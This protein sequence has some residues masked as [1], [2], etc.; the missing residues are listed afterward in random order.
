MKTLKK[1]NRFLNEQGEFE[2][3]INDPIDPSLDNEDDETVDDDERFDNIKD[4][5]FEEDENFIDNDETSS[6]DPVQTMIDKLEKYIAEKQSDVVYYFVPKDLDEDFLN[7][8]IAAVS[9]RYEIEKGVS[10]KDEYDVYEIT[11]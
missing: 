4:A 9:E 2:D 3:D 10:T 11:V 7:D 5:D 8:F 6:G 1:Y